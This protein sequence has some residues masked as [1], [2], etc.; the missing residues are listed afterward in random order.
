MG[1]SLASTPT[2]LLSIRLLGEPALGVNRGLGAQVLWIWPYGQ[3]GT[4]LQSFMVGAVP[5]AP[6]AGPEGWGPSLELT[7]AR[8]GRQSFGL[9]RSLAYGQAPLA[10]AGLKTQALWETTSL[11]EASSRGP[12]EL[13]PPSLYPPALRR[14]SPW[15]VLLSPSFWPQLECL[16]PSR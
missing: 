11:C 8:C 3:A 5:S 16:S 2:P 1:R 4:W 9:A 6:L 10:P 15:M 7:A 13:T 12:V 14:A